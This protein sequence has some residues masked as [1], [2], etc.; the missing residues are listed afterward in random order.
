MK[1]IDI[2]VDGVNLS[3]RFEV[4]TYQR[5]PFSWGASRGEETEIE[6]DAIYVGDVDIT[7]LLTEEKIE[8]IE[9]IVEE[10]L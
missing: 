9:E 2:T 4:E 10:E 8:E 7:K 3:V 5:E 1:W 6:I